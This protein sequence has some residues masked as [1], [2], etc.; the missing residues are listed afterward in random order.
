MKVLVV[1]GGG[2][3]HAICRALAKSKKVD[4]LFAAPGNAGI[5]EV[6][7]CVPIKAT[8]IEGVL[9][10]ALENEI[11]MV[12]VAPDD[13]LYLGMV[14]ALNEAGIRAFGPTKN[15]AE[16]EGSKIFAKELMKKYEIPTAAFEK[17]SD[18]GTAK[19][20][21]DTLT[22]PIV[23]KA[24]GLAL[25]KGVIIAA[26]R[27]EAHK[28]IEDMMENKAFG[29]AGSRVVIEEFLEGPEVSILAFCDGKT[30]KPMIS[31]Q[32]H[33]RA[34]DNDMGKNT[35]GMG[36]FSNSRIYT[37][38]IAKECEEK[39]FLPTVAAMEK[40]GRP[41][42]GVLYFGLMITK[43]GPKVI[44]YNARFGDPETQVI[45]PRMKSDLF[46]IFTAVIDGT[47]AETSV[48]FDENYAVCVIM[49]SGGYPE[50]YETGFEISGI[51][52]AED[53]GAIIYH[54]GTKSENGKILTSG[55]RVL[56]V[57]ALGQSIE[58][59]REKAYECVSKIS[60]HGAH[61]RKDIGIKK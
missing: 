51:G 16:I 11:G 1:G 43:D 42:K 45:L 30:V 31:A 21:I 38:E 55:G 17:F 47:L 57:T 53:C 41:F 4:K 29:D 33:K 36:T 56:G 40:E 13:P 37:P 52:D 14:D 9:A 50:K 35:G 10:F 24:D 48:E 49:A 20:F 46:D 22:P 28:A 54:S 8:D 2:R 26:S 27:E 61:Y 32:D 3:E 59:A 23:V 60:F 44:E 15:A 5:A 19:A 58:K 39:I 12:V 6:A 34:L 18:A 25:G 7:Q